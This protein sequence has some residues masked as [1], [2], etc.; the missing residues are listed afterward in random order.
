MFHK[1]LRP[2]NMWNI[3]L[4]ACTYARNPHRFAMIVV[5]T[6]TR[7]SKGTKKGGGRSPRGELNSKF[8]EESVHFYICVSDFNFTKMTDVGPIMCVHD[9]PPTFVCCT[10]AVDI[11]F[12]T[13]VTDCM[14][15]AKFFK[16]L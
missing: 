7:D 2:W 5:H 10:C 1:V 12:C 8:F 4:T 9:L 6:C 11:W 14:F 3:F 15:F 13:D 16:L